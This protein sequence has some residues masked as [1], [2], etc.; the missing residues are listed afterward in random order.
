MK[1][2]W[3]VNW[4]VEVE[5]HWHDVCGLCMTG[6]PSSR[7]PSQ[8]KP[9]GRLFLCLRRLHAVVCGSPSSPPPSGSDVVCL[10]KNCKTTRS[11]FRERRTGG[12]EEKERRENMTPLFSIPQNLKYYTT[13]HTHTLLF[14]KL[15]ASEIFISVGRLCVCVRGGEVAPETAGHHGNRWWVCAHLCQSDTHQ[16]QEV[17]L[18][19]T[20]RFQRRICETLFYF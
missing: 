19:M 4:N 5:L 9:N 18:Q 1:I 16:Q 3:T 13:A 7:K 17:L 20:H 10:D 8:D 15:S 12:T 14:T 2:T 6:Q 11:N